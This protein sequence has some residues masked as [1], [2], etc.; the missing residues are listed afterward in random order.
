MGAGAGLGSKRVAQMFGQTNV[1]FREKI[2]KGNT[3]KLLK[4]FF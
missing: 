3:E 2:D 4:I 1:R